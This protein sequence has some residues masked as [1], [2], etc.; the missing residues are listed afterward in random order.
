MEFEFATAGRIIFGAGVSGRLAELAAANGRRPL[1]V[2]GSNPDRHGELLDGLKATGLEYEVF[3]VAGE[4]SVELV[5]EAAGRAWAQ[6]RDSVVGIGGGSVLDAAKAVSALLANDGGALDYLEVVGAGKKISRPAVP[7]I[8]APTTAG[9]GSEV[10]R[11]AVL[12]VPDR[13]V[14]VSLR[15]RLIIPSVALVDP[16]LTR[17]LPP[18]LTA[19]AGMDALAQLIEAFVSPRSHP[20]T[21]ALCWAGIRRAAG[22]LPAAWKDGSDLSAREAMSLAAM[23]SGIG[24]ANSGLGA[25]HG[26]AGPLGG[27]LGAP[28]GALCARLLPEVLENNLKRLREAEEKESVKRFTELAVA[29]TGNPRARAE[30]AIERTRGLVSRFGIPPLARHG[31]KEEDIDG[32]AGAALGS[33]SLK[34][35]PVRL[36]QDELAAIIKKA[37]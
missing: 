36:D 21:D 19:A 30:D 4:P 11:N 35:N 28:H 7:F 15:H 27:L 6:G 1:V 17:T 3:T 29:L 25:V 24:L 26:L 13:K 34:G 10:T 32:V 37:L 22:A 5:D 8:A 31:L 14:K 9:T 33:S 2:C 23:L 18:E 16:L 12:S 20:M